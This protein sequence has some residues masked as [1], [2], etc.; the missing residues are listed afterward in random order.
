MI[1]YLSQPTKVMR[2]MRLAVFSIAAALS[3][4]LA[5]GQLPVTEQQAIT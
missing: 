4:M 3:S 1:F 2:V 5:E